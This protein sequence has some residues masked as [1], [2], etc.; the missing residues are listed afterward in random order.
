MQKTRGKLIVLEGLDGSGITT[1]A[2]LLAQYL[3][4]KKHCQVVSTSEPTQGP[5]GLLLRLIL[6]GRLNLDGST[7]K[8]DTLPNSAMALLFAADRLD[9]IHHIIQPKLEEGKIVICERYYLSSYAYQ[10]DKDKKNL[11]WLRTINTHSLNPDLIIFLNVPLEICSQRRQTRSYQEIYEQNEI[12]R[13]VAENY[14]YVIS[15]LKKEIPIEEI[16]GNNSENDIL[17]KIIGI[18]EHYFSNLF[19]NI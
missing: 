5:I 4:N 10:M 3:E 6:S 13:R 7:L 2:K 15:Q 8:S 14:H 17:Q 18:I 9:H 11:D 1:Q 12:L 16:D 19:C